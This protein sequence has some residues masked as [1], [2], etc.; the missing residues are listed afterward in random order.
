LFKEH[1]TLYKLKISGE[2]TKISAEIRIR[3]RTKDDSE[4]KVI[5]ET[6]Q[7]KY[8]LRIN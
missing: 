7:A 6:T 1:N 5:K 4:Y 8:Y 2:E 3:G